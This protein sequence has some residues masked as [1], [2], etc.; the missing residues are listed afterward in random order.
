MPDASTQTEENIASTRRPLSEASKKK[1]DQA[2]KR[3]KDA[4]LDIE[5]QHKEVIAWIKEKGSNSAQLTYY[6][7][8]KYE[9]GKLDKPFAFPTAY[10]NE[11]DRLASIQNKKQNDQELT[12]KQVQNF[13]PYTDLLAVQQKLSAK[14]NKSDKEWR[15]YLVASLY[16]LQPPVR[17]DYGAVQVVGKRLSSREGNQL[18]WG[19]KKGAHF[20]FK[21][22]K[23]KGAY[24]TVEVRVSPALHA[25]IAEWFGHLGKRP[26]YL[27]GRAITPNDL[28]AEIQHAFHT[29]RKTI[30]INLLRHAYIKHHYPELTTIKQKE[31]LARMMLHSKDKQEA[32]N[33]QNV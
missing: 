16:T 9:L 32:Y 20:I 33:S 8:L 1:Y 27:L 6:A 22:Y 11:I 4:G 5:T 15:D 10:Q 7:A 3:I 28:L 18:V 23:T 29:T 19:Q 12:E 25:V 13:V 26:K 21:D 24:G 2:I 17:A 31:D 30:G 14:E